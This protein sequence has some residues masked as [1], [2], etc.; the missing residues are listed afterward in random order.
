M[1][2]K[3]LNDAFD[4]FL[5]KY[6][7]VID[8]ALKSRAYEGDKGESLINEFHEYLLEKQSLIP[9]SYL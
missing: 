7:T 5:G 4:L 3:D 2:P 1:Y 9:K 6:L 8:E